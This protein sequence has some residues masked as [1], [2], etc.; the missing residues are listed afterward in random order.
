MI[1]Q[2]VSLI[3]LND[4]Q[5]NN[6]CKLL[7]ANSCLITHEIWRRNENLIF[8]IIKNKYM[9]VFF[10]FEQT[11]IKIFQTALKNI[12]IQIHID[13]VIIDECYL[14]KQWKNFQSA[15]TILNEFKMIF[16]QNVIWFNCSAI[17]NEKTKQ[18]ILFSTDF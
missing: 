1:F 16:H 12:L 8:N 10:D 14:V 5:L 7:K 11:S 18:L 13:L 15:F 9:H 3:K 6:I 2:I 4:K 17:L